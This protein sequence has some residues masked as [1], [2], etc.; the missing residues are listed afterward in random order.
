[1]DKGNVKKII[2]LVL[3]NYTTKR[4][5]A[6]WFM[7]RVQ[8]AYLSILNNNNKNYLALS[9]SHPICLSPFNNYELFWEEYKKS[10]VSFITGYL[11]M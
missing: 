8:N 11:S 6:I 7:I 5:K 9:P 10:W 2:V 3:L 4:A 1:M